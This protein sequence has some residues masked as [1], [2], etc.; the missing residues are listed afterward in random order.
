MKQNKLTVGILGGMGA[1]ASVR[2][3]EEVIRA[4]TSVFG[5]SENEDFPQLLIANLPIPDIVGSADK[6]M[7]AE[8]RI[9][10][11]GQNLQRAGADCL[12]MACN[13]A[14]I[15]FDSLQN[16]VNIP[17]LNL[18]EETVAVL[19]DSTN[20][21]GVLATPTT[22]STGLYQKALIQAGFSFI[23]PS[24][25]EQELLEKA[26]LSTIADR[27]GAMET[28]VLVSIIDRM[29]SE[30]A[31]AVILGCT[32]LGLIVSESD[33]VLPLVDSVVAGARKTAELGLGISSLLRSRFL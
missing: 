25:G 6:K 24:E 9:I 11:G 15:C 2:F 10:E 8:K 27:N 18:I 21:V 14:H 31:E 28:A 4:C 30:G 12:I 22:L 7:L 26:I 13:T 3:Y 20:I 5:V 33:I 17:V 1:R 16:A 32:E 23:L 19:P 29:Q